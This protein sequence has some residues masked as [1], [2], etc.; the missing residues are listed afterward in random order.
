MCEDLAL[1]SK[2]IPLNFIRPVHDNLKAT[3][4]DHWEALRASNP[5]VSGHTASLISA[6][7]CIQKA[8][9]CFAAADDLPPILV[10]VENLLATT[11][12][13]ERKVKA[14]NI[15]M[16]APENLDETPV[17]VQME[18]LEGCVQTMA[19]LQGITLSGDIARAC[20]KVLNIFM[21]KLTVFLRDP[22]QAFPHTEFLKFWAIVVGG[23]PS[24]A[25][26]SLYELVMCAVNLMRGMK[27]KE[28]ADATEVSE[29]SSAQDFVDFRSLMVRV[30]AKDKAAKEVL[31]KT[32]LSFD[33]SGFVT[34]VG[35][36][37]KESSDFVVER[38]KGE[39]E[40]S[41]KA[42]MDS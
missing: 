3:I 2:D 16:T 21:P 27:A 28:I 40:V 23:V 30:M 15:F 31:Q 19:E 41:A 38:M 25:M 18:F 24:E 11:D 6:K 1:A 37:I 9:S 8:I 13:T 14:M 12:T 35:S 4:L 5:D 10:Q 26:A 34:A 33:S 36:G 7:A 22:A 29:E 39:L 42:F 17:K 32:P 20:E